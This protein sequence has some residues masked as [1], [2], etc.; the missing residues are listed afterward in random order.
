[1]GRTAG[2]AAGSWALFIDG[3]TASWIGFYAF[4]YPRGGLYRLLFPHIFPR[5]NEPDIYQPL[6]LRGDCL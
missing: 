5:D 3:P 4:F 1:M 2:F 6:F